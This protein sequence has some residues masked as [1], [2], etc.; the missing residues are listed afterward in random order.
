MNSTHRAYTLALYPFTR[1]FAFVLFE[2]PS[3]PID[4]GVKE[5]RGGEKNAITLQAVARLVDRYAPETIVIEDMKDTESRRHLRIRALYRLIAI[6]ARSRGIDVARYRHAD[7]LKTF[8][9]VGARTKYEIAQA[10]AE[11]IP[12][13]SIRLP[14]KRKI[15]MTED[16]RQSL[17]DAAAL[18]ITHFSRTSSDP[19]Q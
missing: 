10:I 4:W 6:L 9:S 1:G 7:V 3:S 14:R 5:L 13:F 8:A 19:G 15:W 12:A 2:G 11:Q 16:P 18:G 17:F